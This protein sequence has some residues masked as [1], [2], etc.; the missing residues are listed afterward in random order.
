MSTQQKCIVECNFAEI[1]FFVLE[2][3]VQSFHWKNAQ[4]TVYYFV[5]YFNNRNKKFKTTI[6]EVY[7]I[8]DDWFKKN[9]MSLNIVKTYYI[10]FTAKIRCDRDMGDLGTIITCA[11]YT[12]F[13]GL[14]IQNYIT[15]F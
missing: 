5:I 3:E 11:N 13:L 2:D 15:W 6:N 4:T 1:Y 9:L 8:L 12:K 14:T 10:N 7:R